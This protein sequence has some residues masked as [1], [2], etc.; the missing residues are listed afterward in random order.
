MDLAFFAASEAAETYAVID[1]FDPVDRQAARARVQCSVRLDVDG[2]APGRHAGDRV[3]A[4]AQ[5]E[6]APNSKIRRGRSFDG[7]SRQPALAFVALAVTGA[8]RS[9]LLIE[10]GLLDDLRRY[11][12]GLDRSS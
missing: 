7:H 6:I 11:V 2:V 4:V 3:M 10:I 1:D 9:D 12:L 5:L 8:G